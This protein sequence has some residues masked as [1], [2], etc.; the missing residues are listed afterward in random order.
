ML[1]SSRAS[2]PQ[3]GHRGAGR[4]V[5]DDRGGIFQDSPPVDANVGTPPEG[6]FFAVGVHGAGRE[7]TGQ[8]EGKGADY[9]PFEVERGRSVEYDV[10]GSGQLHADRVILEHMIKYWT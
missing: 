1:G 10:S 8:R 4:R 2:L 7:M 6:V 9:V 3:E 5:P